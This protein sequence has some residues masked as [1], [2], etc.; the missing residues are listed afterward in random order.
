MILLNVAT[1]RTAIDVAEASLIASRVAAGDPNAL[2]IQGMQSLLGSSALVLDGLRQRPRYFDGRFLTGADLT[3]DQDYVRQRQADMARA[4]GTG[5]VAG[6][7]VSLVDG[8]AG[9]S[10]RIEAGQGITPSG[11]L[12]LI[13]AAMQ[14]DMTDLPQ[15][16]Q[17]DAA[18]GLKLRPSQPLARRTGLFILSL[19]PIEYTA[20]PIA[21]YPTSITGPRSVEDGDIIEATAVTL[22]P[23]PDPGG[24]AS[25]EEARRMVARKIFVDGSSN[26]I[27]QD[28]LPL[29][30][31]ALDGG[32]IRWLDMAMVRRETGAETPL[33]VALGN[34]PR[35]LAEAHVLQYDAQLA[36]VLAARGRAGTSGAFAAGQ[37]FAALPAAG[38]MPSDAIL[39][40]ALG[41]T[42][43]YFPTSVGVDLSFVPSDEIA[44]LVEES[45]A[46]PPI[47]LLADPADLTGTGVVVLVPVTRQRL[48]LLETQ[49]AK[50]TRAASANDVP[51]AR[52]A[53][54]ELL[55][56]LLQRRAALVALRLPVPAAPA[57]PD[58]TVTA[59]QAAWRAAVAA[60][61]DSSGLLW[62]VRR[63]TVAYES[64]LV[65]TAVPA[66]GDD[67]GFAAALDTRLSAIGLAARVG[68]LRSRATPFANARLTAFLGSARIL[69]SDLLLSAAVRGLEARL[70]TAATPVVTS[71]PA[72]P[73]PLTE[74]DVLTV[75]ETFGAPLLGDGLTR[76]LAAYGVP[77][78]TATQVQWLA[79]SGHV[80]DLDQI[81]H[82]VSN[83]NLPTLAQHLRAVVAASDI[84]GLEN[85]LAAGA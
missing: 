80:L 4:S 44:A 30:M 58:P 70:T 2:S 36:D 43:A 77:A 84:V 63:R 60:N 61:P 69:P 66:S 47:D 85:L 68:V 35:A 5:V 49:L 53:P 17:L 32:V 83:A 22:I 75:A 45:L 3:R 6:L 8:L 7:Q 21:A 46:L 29:A 71:P 38:R 50:L 31:L 14:V 13:S 56:S 16:D 23:Y 41:F 72:A 51:V 59:W 39:L 73:L 40:D 27:P 26:G 62:Y 10:V 11:D 57:A 76:L 37:Y 15:I 65:G 78:L 79:N 19:R 34:R 1:A 81:A 12:V 25:L 28:A 48:Q 55:G 67:A 64:Q 18:L 42:Q 20:N 33:Q 24:S 82:D 9:T 74:G 52:R 54:I